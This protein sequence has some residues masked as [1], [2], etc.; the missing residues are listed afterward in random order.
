[1]H[2][3]STSHDTSIAPCST[4]TCATLSTIGLGAYIYT[5]VMNQGYKL[6]RVSSTVTRVTLIANRIT[7]ARV[8][9][10]VKVLRV[11]RAIII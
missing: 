5:H 8:V 1:M 9:K 6:I 10:V 3:H 7:V 4:A 11:L 2:V